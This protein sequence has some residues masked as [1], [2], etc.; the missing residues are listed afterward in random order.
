VEDTIGFIRPH[1]RI[2][3]KVQRSA[4]IADGCRAILDDR[5]ALERMARPGTVVKVRHLFL[6]ADPKSRRKQG[7]WRKDL[8]TC[9]GRLEKKGAIIKD[10]SSGLSTANPEHRYLLVEGA[11]KA[12]A[13][14]GRTVHLEKKRSGRRPMVFST[15]D[16]NK[17][18]K[19]WLNVKRYPTEAEAQT[20]MPEGFSTSR[21]RKLWG[22][23]KY[24]QS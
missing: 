8:L 5:V 14:N 21:A 18:E 20:A 11:I 1:A 3:E 6:L 9:M 15:D 10:V 12:L 13:S 19:V 16:N 22:P 7:G 17:A 23:R 4:L 24:S 2:G